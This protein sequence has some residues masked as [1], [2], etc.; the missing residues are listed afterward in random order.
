[1]DEAKPTRL[2]VIITTRDLTAQVVSIAQRFAPQLAE[3]GGEVLIVGGRAGAHGD[4]LGGARHIATDDPDFM[5]LRACGLAEAR[6]DVVAIGEDHAFPAEGWARAVL[7]AHDE[8]PDVPMVLGC[9]VNVTDRTA[10]ARA[11]FLGFAA[12]FTPPMP[13]V[14]GRPPP[15]SVVSIKRDALGDAARHPGD[16][17]NE[18]LPRLHREGRVVADDRI[19]AE[20]WQPFGPW[21]SFSNGFDITRASYGYAR[22]RNGARPLA[23]AARLARGVARSIWYEATSRRKLS[24]GPRRDLVLIALIAAASGVGAGVGAR[25][26]PG[27][28]ADRA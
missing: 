19:V 27:S 16:F 15:I 2:S 12:P 9:L 24:G 26:G 20:H 25:W 23:E 3:V 10:A 7:R 8:H 18:V 6:G 13:D 22:T 21:A 1:M 5:R 14:P 11:S 4:T 17:E 28:S